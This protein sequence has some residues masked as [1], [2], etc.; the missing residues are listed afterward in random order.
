M[1]Y[2]YAPPERIDD[3]CVVIDGDELS[4]LVHVMRKKAGD[5]IMVVD[6]NGCAYDV[7]LETVTKRSARGVIRSMYRAYHE[8]AS[9]VTL[10]V[11]I[12]KNPSRFDFLVEKVTEIGVI[13]IIPLR[14]ERTIPSRAK[15]DRWQKLALAAMKQCGRSRLPRVK[16]LTSL[17][18]LLRTRETYRRRFIA[19]VE[20]NHPTS[21]GESL[22]AVPDS[23]LILVGPEG[24]FSEDEI[25]RCVGA[26]FEPVVLGDRR[27]RTETAAIALAT[28]TILEG[29]R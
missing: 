1:D 20:A 7:L 9:Q 27:L 4:H 18:D 5:R 12:L 11:G 29:G 16:E 2:F 19:H 13:G 17:D 28:L 14:T 10:A 15:T 25:A 6:G 3:R 24:G 21:A 23:T 26:G 8:P 22:S